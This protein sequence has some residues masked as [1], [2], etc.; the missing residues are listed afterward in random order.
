MGTRLYVLRLSGCS[1]SCTHTRTLDGS[2]TYFTYKP[3]SLLLLFLSFFL[4]AVSGAYLQYGSTPLSDPHPNVTLTVG[5]TIQRVL[6]AQATGPVP[7]SI[8]WYSPQGQLVSRNN[9]DVV[10]QADIRGRAAVLNFH[11]YQQNQGGQY[12]CRVAGPRNNTESLSVCI[13]ECYIYLL[14]VKPATC[15]FFLYQ[16]YTYTTCTTYTPYKLAHV[17]TIQLELC[18]GG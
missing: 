10:N 15:E 12:E 7:T 1:V 2:A 8:E 14:L 5:T 17:V 3:V 4:T 18:G 11:S 16:V 13:G 9:S 6:C